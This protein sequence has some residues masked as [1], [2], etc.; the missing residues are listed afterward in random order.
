MI[1][2][3]C[4]IMGIGPH[5][6]KHSCRSFAA[7][8]KSIHNQFAVL[9]AK[10]IWGSS[11]KRVVGDVYSCCMYASDC[12]ISAVNDHMNALTSASCRLKVAINKNHR[13]RTFTSACSLKQLQMTGFSE[14]AFPLKDQDTRSFI[15]NV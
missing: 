14:P 11:L 8:L 12:I 13:V 3:R 4:L 1:D 10:Q 7:A 6:L 2:L 9:C 5:L 15:I